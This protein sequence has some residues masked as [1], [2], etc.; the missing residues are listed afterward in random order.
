M[1]DHINLVKAKAEQVTI[2]LAKKGV[3]KTPPLRV[4]ADYDVSGSMSNLFR[5]GVV[6]RA[7]DQV[8]GVGYKFD[9]DGQVDSF[10]FDNRASYVGTSTVD[11]YGTF[12][13]DTILS[14][15]DLWG[16]TNYGG[17]LQANIDFLFGAGVKSRVFVPGKKGLFGTSKGSWKEETF[18]SSGKDPALVLFFTDGAPDGGDRSAQII[19]DASKRGLPVYFALIGVGGA[20]FRVLKKLA[21][22]YDNCGFVNL[23]NFNL[24]DAQ[25]YD[26]L[27]GTDEFIAFLR[28]HGAS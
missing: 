19:S 5:S 26:Q 7:S 28:K 10:I 2:S 12:V 8:L 20:D 14:R 3:T 11:D 9:D 4:V 15:Q 17:C 23:S 13:N 1:S 18:K 24:T 22:D 27:V 21:D 6:Q 16:S 25:L